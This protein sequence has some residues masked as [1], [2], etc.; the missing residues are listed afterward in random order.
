M[1]QGQRLD[2]K[3][4]RMNMGT[5]WVPDWQTMDIRYDG[6]YGGE[7]SAHQYIVTD[8]ENDNIE[9]GRFP[10]EEIKLHLAG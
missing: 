1:F 5:Q 7:H 4:V 9:M 3:Q 6:Q 10:E 2:G 8:P